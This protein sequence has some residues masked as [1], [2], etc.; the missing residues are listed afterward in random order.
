MESCTWKQPFAASSL[1][2][3]SLLCTE[4]HFRVVPTPDNMNH[5]SH[6]LFIGFCGSEIIYSLTDLNAMKALVGSVVHCE[7]VGCMLPEAEPLRS[8][9]HV[10]NGEGLAEVCEEVVGVPVVGEGAAVVVVVGHVVRTISP[11]PTLLS[12]TLGRP[13]GSEP[14]QQTDPPPAPRHPHAFT[15]SL[16]MSLSRFSSQ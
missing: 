12:P 1:S 13:V 4:V 7:L 8:K 16:S 3:T 15:S 2:H 14:H 10:A 11:L 5:I 6:G 9:V